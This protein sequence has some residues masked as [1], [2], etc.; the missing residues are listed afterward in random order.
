M[1]M[2]AAMKHGLE[3]YLESRIHVYAARQFAVSGDKETAEK[4]YKNALK[5]NPLNPEIWKGLVSLDGGALNKAR[6]AG[7]LATTFSSSK[8][9]DES[10]R[11]FVYHFARAEGM[12]TLKPVE[13]NQKANQE[14]LSMLEQC[15]DS[16]VPVQ[17]AM[18]RFQVAVHGWRVSR[19]PWTS[20]WRPLVITKETEKTRRQPA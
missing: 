15:A 12:D 1:G 6:V 13:G 7:L 4:V 2:T 9:A 8:G 10:S 14:I 16:A 5:A 17:L 11:A 20:P 19:N 3:A 18:I